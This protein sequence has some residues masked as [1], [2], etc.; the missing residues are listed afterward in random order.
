VI[1]Q[2]GEAITKTFELKPGN[3]GRAR[4]C[5]TATCPGVS[6]PMRL[7]KYWVDDITAGA[8][9]TF[10]LNGDWEM[11]YAPGVEPGA[12]PPAGAT[13]TPIKVPSEQPTSK[14]HVAWFRKSFQAPPYLR[15]ERLVLECDE[16]LSTATVY[17]NGALCGS[18][19]RGSEPFEVDV[20]AG[21]KP[22]AQNELLIAVRDWLAYSP[23]N[24]ELRPS[25]FGGR[26]S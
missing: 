4:L 20:T 14:G 18:T 5:V 23:R 24:R 25:A 21:F 15:G 17:L 9:P 7:T 2:P 11:C 6:P 26:S 3:T 22:G 19:Q 10:G 13:W 12:I 8:R 1:L 16:I